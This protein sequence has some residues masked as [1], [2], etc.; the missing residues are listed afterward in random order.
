M[1]RRRQAEHLGQA[2]LRRRDAVRGRRRR[3]SP[4]HAGGRLPDH[5]LHRFPG[6]PPDDPQHVQDRRRDAAHRLPCDR[7]FTGVPVPRHLRRPLRRD[8]VP[9]HRIRHA[10]R[11]LRPGR[12][13][14]GAGRTPLDIS[15]DGSIPPVLRRLPHQP[16]SPQVRGNPLRDH[17]KDGRPRGNR[18]IP[19]PRHAPRSASHKG[20]RPERR[21]LLP[22]T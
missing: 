19:R 20:R 14:H 2:G 5:H 9:Q 15:L 10:R 21:R 4:R 7:P 12:D 6:A 11:K 1:G 3:R 16:R 17:C 8:G 18:Q 22:G 13:G